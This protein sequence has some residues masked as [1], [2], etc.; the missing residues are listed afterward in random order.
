MSF[1]VNKQW[2]MKKL[3]KTDADELFFAKINNPIRMHI[4]YHSN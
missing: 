3:L 4:N 1:R 2:E